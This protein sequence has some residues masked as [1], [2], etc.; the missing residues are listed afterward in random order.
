MVY[1]FVKSS[2]VKII[3]NILRLYVSFHLFILIKYWSLIQ[4]VHNETGKL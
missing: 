2:F 1:R 4:V 3:Q